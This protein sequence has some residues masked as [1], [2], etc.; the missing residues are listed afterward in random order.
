M[1]RED[2]DQVN[3]LTIF[4]LSISFIDSRT[5]AKL[6]YRDAQ[7]VIEGQPLGDVPVI[8][9][10]DPRDIAH[11]IRV[12]SDLARQLRRERFRNGALSLN[13]PQLKFQLDESGLPLDCGEYEV[14]D[15]NHLVEEVGMK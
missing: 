3:L 15:S 9:E 8:P 1:V 2:C 6:S 12:L 7:N 13:P 5:A 11:D 4:S 14:L 10:H